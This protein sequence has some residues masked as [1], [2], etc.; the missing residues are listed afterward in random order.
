MCNM[1]ILG[2]ILCSGSSVEHVCKVL[3]WREKYTSGLQST[4]VHKILLTITRSEFYQSDATVL[5]CHAICKVKHHVKSNCIP[6]PP[7]LYF[8]YC[9]LPEKKQQANTAKTSVHMTPLPKTE[10]QAI[11][12]I[13]NQWYIYNHCCYVSAISCKLH[14]IYC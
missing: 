10:K 12:N 2:K 9:S 14:E 11:N 5:Q 1:P 6:P 13:E 3:R 7:A 4:N 8:C